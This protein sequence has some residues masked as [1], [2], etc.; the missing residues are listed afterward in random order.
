MT[1]IRPKTYWYA[2]NLYHFDF[3]NLAPPLKDVRFFFFDFNHIW[4]Y[5]LRR[6]Y[7]KGKFGNLCH[8]ITLLEAILDYTNLYESLSW[9]SK[10]FKSPKKLV[11]RMNKIFSSIICALLLSTE[12][13]FLVHFLCVM[14]D[15]N[16]FF[17]KLACNYHKTCMLLAILGLQCS[18]KK[19]LD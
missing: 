14:G 13:P 10:V 6:I 16:P 8:M 1:E 12:K 18:L 17:I 5:T 9:R 3:L 7:P 11:F 19:W 2:F 15:L 4:G